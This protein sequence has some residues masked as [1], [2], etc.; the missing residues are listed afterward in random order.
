MTEPDIV[1]G[2][3]EFQ[4]AARLYCKQKN[5]DPDERISLATAS[6]ESG[7]NVIGPRWKEAAAILREH[8]LRDWCLHR[9]GWHL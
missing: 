7:L 2:L 1:P 4:T 9:G 3:D 8:Y 6:R 5:A